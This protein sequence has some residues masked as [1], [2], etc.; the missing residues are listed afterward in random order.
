MACTCHALLTGH[1][2]LQVSSAELQIR[3]VL[4]YT[5]FGTKLKIRLLAMSLVGC[6][7]QLSAAVVAELRIC[8]WFCMKLGL[9]HAMK[10]CQRMHDSA[11]MPFSQKTTEQSPEEVLQCRAIIRRNLTHSR[12]GYYAITCAGQWA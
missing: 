4:W 2:G 9:L 5:C 12:V 11:V 1:A 10:T 6:C 7:W 8:A 3:H